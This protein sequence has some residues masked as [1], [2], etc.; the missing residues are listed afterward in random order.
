MLVADALRLGGAILGNHPDMLA[1]QLIGRLL[2][3][4]GANVNVRMLLRACDHD[5]VKNCALL[6]LYHCLHTPGG[7]LKVILFIYIAIYLI[8]LVRKF[9]VSKKLFAI[10]FNILHKNTSYIN[11]LYQKN[12]ENYFFLS[13]T[14]LSKTF[15]FANLRD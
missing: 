6:P 11:I 7:P 4:I 2:P 14:F 3:E 10:S 13:K 15:N 1:P 12:I 5:G 9:H 8:L